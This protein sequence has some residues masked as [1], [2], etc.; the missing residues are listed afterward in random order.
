ML[1][2]TDLKA[3]NMYYQYVRFTRRLDRWRVINHVR[4][5]KYC[6]WAVWNDVIVWRHRIRIRK[7]RAKIPPEWGALWTNG[8]CGWVCRSMIITRL[9][10][11][12]EKKFYP[13]LN[14]SN[15]FT[16]ITVM[17]ILFAKYTMLLFSGLLSCVKQIWTFK[18]N[19][20]YCLTQILVIFSS[21]NIKIETL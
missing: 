13:K 14:V 8:V 11:E 3:A 19:C 16:L 21:Y 6:Q 12:L 7:Y 10:K 1:P 9:N 18:I 2:H 15:Y 5:M 17:V 20:P 4:C